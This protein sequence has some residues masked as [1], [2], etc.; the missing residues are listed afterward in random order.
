MALTSEAFSQ[1]PQILKL[2]SS[3]ND[4]VPGTAKKAAI[5]LSKKCLHSIIQLPESVISVAAQTIRSLEPQYIAALN[6]QL[7]SVDVPQ[8][9][10]ALMV[11][12][13]FISEKR[14]EEILRSTLKHP[15]NKIR[16]TAVLHIGLKASKTNA[17]IL[18][19]FL[20]DS[21]NRVKANTIEVFER[22]KNKVFVRILNR[23]RKDPNNRLRANAL[24]ALYTMREPG[25]KNDL[26]SML[27]EPKALMRVSAVW[28]IGEIGKTSPGYIKLLNM[29]KND[30]DD[31]VRRNLLLVLRKV[32]SVP[33]ADFLRT[34]LKGDL[35][36]QLK[37]KIVEKKD[38]KIEQNQTGAYYGLK[39]KGV[40]TAQSVLALK[41]LLDELIGKESR[42]V[43]DLT[44]VDYIDSSGVGLLVNFHKNLQKR[45]GFVFL[46]GCNYKISELIQLSGIDKILSIF[47]TLEEVHEFLVLPSADCP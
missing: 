28:V 37:D 39:L 3:K 10:E 9:V 25:I 27:M 43:F 36:Q 8:T 40:I 16:A 2:I 22:L 20:E 21:D 30:P 12:K 6:D 7:H 4:K 13:H 33:E 19:K 26:Q 38:L 34:A 45:N 17:E 31:M 47:H 46:F 14:A 35:Q 24:K 44:N 15:S 42:F 41:L 32:G 1:L 29:T 5:D 23:F 11:L 18:S